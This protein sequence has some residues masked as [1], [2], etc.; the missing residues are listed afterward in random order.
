MLL[1]DRVPDALIGR[2]ISQRLAMAIRKIGKKNDTPVVFGKQ[3]I[4]TDNAQVESGTAKRIG[5]LYL[6]CI[7]EFSAKDRAKDLLALGLE[8]KRSVVRTGPGFLAIQSEQS[9]P[10][11]RSCCLVRLSS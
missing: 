4:D 2:R 9:R 8:T 11:S 10:C 1:I 3:T 5:V 7:A 6:T